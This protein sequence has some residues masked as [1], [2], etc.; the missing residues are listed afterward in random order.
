MHHDPSGL[1]NDA[2]DISVV[3]LKELTKFICDNKNVQIKLQFIYVT[4]TSLPSPELSSAE[5]PWSLVC[6]SS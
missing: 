1:P 2:A 3:N 6:V 4:W 5:P